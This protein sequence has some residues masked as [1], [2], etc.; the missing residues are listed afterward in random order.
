MAT[1]EKPRKW[2]NAEIEALD[3]DVD[4]ARIWQLGNAYRTSPMILNMAVCQGF[5]RLVGPGSGARTLVRGGKGKVVLHQQRRIEG[6]MH[7]VWTWYLGEG[8]HDPSVRESVERVN[9][10]HDAWA[11]KYPD[12][13]LDVRQYTYTMCILAAE[14]HRVMQRLGLPGFSA[15]EQRAAYRHWSQIAGLFRIG[16]DQGVPLP[17]DFDGMLAFLADFERNDYSTAPESNVVAEAML[18]QFCDRWFPRPLHGLGRALVLSLATPDLLAV[19]GL[20]GP[21]P[22]VVR[23]LRRTLRT[24]ITVQVRWAPD[25]VEVA[26][27]RAA[28]AEPRPETPMGGRLKAALSGMRG[29]RPVPD[30]STSTDV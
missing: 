10:Q 30:G 1:R 7:A 8:A 17:A 23:T 29:Q 11:G 16:S 19:H 27:I 3:P 26:P 15:N 28:F 5:L 21:R 25:P 9:R 20:K 24:L 14:P 13:I 2:I 12:A 22:L 4:H 18:Q 6:T